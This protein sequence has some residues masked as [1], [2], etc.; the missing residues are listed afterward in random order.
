[1]STMFIA[2]LWIGIG[3]AVAKS[4]EPHP[5]WMDLSLGIALAPLWLGIAIYEAIEKMNKP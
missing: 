2:L 5:K 3:M 4:I 1:M